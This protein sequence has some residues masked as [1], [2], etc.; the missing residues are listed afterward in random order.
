MSGNN[1]MEQSQ[2][3]VIKVNG[4]SRA[5][6]VDVIET[7]GNLSYQFVDVDGNEVH[8]SLERFKEDEEDVYEV[9]IQTAMSGQMLQFP[10]FTKAINYFFELVQENPCSKE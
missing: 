10:D 5:T 7:H 3:I 2:E 6:L 4:L 9:E 8:I 1:E